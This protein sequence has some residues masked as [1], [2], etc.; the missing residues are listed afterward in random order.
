MPWTSLRSALLK[1]AV[2]P[3]RLTLVEGLSA[4]DALDLF[5]GEGVDY[6]QMPHP[7]AQTLIEQG[8]GHLVTALGPESGYICYS[9]FA[10]MPEFIETRPDT[11][12]R[13]VDG[14]SKAL[15]WLAAADDADIVERVSPLFPD[16]SDSTLEAAIH[17]Y[18]IQK[19][20]PSDP[21]IGE[22]G[23]TTMRDL[24]I[25]AGLVRGRHPYESV[26]RPEFARKAMER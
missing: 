8:V 26:V 23:Y 22:D 16:L 12:Q 18:R 2:D 24:M 10:A 25:D 20:W 11:V 15:T 19:T 7:Q 1:N 6:I 4:G 17:Q 14:F 13:F 21:A 9:S 5:R 3:G